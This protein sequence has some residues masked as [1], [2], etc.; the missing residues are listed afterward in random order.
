VVLA[1]AQGR[2]LGGLSALDNLFASNFSLNWDRS[3]RPVG[4][5]GACSTMRSWLAKFASLSNFGTAA[6]RAGS[7][8]RIPSTAKP[9]LRSISTTLDEAA[10]LGYW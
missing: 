7:A 3:F 8:S 4:S 1:D 10:G 9:A 6:A 5:A 2:M